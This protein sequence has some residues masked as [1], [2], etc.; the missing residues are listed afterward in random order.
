L[1]IL[2]IYLLL[3]ELTLLMLVLLKGFK[4]ADIKQ[5][6]YSTDFNIIVEYWRSIFSFP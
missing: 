3:Q 6:L 1:N 2:F 4:G 5:S